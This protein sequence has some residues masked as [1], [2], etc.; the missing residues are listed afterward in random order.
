MK[1][2][3]FNFLHIDVQGYELEVLKGAVKCLENVYYIVVEINRS[4]LYEF[5]PMISDI[6]RFLD[7][8]QRVETEWRHGR[9]NWGDALYVRTI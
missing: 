9:E 7:N 1:D 8:F 3:T 6:D 5:C 2:K 4:E